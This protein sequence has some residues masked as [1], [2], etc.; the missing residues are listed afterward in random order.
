MLAT[1]YDLLLPIALDRQKNGWTVHLMGT[2]ATLP[3]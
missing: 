2:A 3:Q 1:R